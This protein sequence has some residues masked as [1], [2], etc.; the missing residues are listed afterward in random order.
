MNDAG[1]AIQMAVEFIS[2]RLDHGALHPGDRLPA[3]RALARM[4]GISERSMIKAIAEL[5]KQGLIF[6][7]RGGCLRAGSPA[8]GVVSLIASPQKFWHMKKSEI[9]KDILSGAFSQ[10]GKLPSQKELQNRYGASYRTMRKILHVLTVEGV[11]RAKGKSHEIPGVPLQKAANRIVFITHAFKFPARSALN[12]EQY[13]LIDRLEHECIRRELRLEVM[14]LDFSDSQ[15]VLRVMSNPV[16]REQSLG[17]VLDVWWTQQ[18]HAQYESLL[19]KLVKIKKPVAIVDEWGEYPLP[20]SQ[21]TNPSVQVYRIEGKGAGARIARLL[22]NLKHRSIAYISLAPDSPW[23]LNR[24]AG[25]QE[26]FSSAGDSLKV[27]TFTDPESAEYLDHILVLSGF[28][29]KLINKIITI[30]QTS[31]QAA[32]RYRQFSRVRLKIKPETFD[33]H[34]VKR[35]REILAPLADAV[36]G[37]SES[38]ALESVNEMVMKKANSCMG[39]MLLAPLFN[40]ALDYRDITAWVC[41]SDITAFDALQFLDLKKVRVPGDISVAG[42]D[43]LP[44]ETASRRLTSLDFNAWGFA[45]RMLDF[46]IRPPR[47]RGTYRHFPVEIEGTIM[48]RGTTGKAKR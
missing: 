7:I 8:S 15:S 14:E 42:F 48:M 34:E 43:N 46:L 3:T 44:V 18:L 21:S 28:G 29:E 30:G 17:F 37:T 1:P 35:L 32:E 45:Y 24:L 13:P 2:T 41:A 39:P 26:Q 20:Q 47:P 27:R 11:V 5:K 23:S 16:I 33:S 19:E 6:G 4:I 31:G 38:R 40:K 9:E 22:M 36:Q 12:P 10:T 25:I